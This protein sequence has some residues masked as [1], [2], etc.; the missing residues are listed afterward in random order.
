MCVIR[1]QNTP[2]SQDDCSPT[3]GVGKK[4]KKT[5]GGTRG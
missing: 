1:D 4:D 2:S 5:P 3:T